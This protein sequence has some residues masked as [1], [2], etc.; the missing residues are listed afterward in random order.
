MKKTLF[1]IF[2]GLT[3]LMLFSGCANTYK[4]D[5]SFVKF[6]LQT[7]K[8][9]PKDCVVN[10]I[11]LPSNICS[12]TIPFERKK[13]ILA[14]SMIKDDSLKYILF[15]NKLVYYKNALTQKVQE[16]LFY[17]VKNYLAK[18]RIKVKSITIHHFVKVYANITINNSNGKVYAVGKISKRIIDKV[19]ENKNLVK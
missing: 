12:S 19:F 11:N 7:K 5:N 13:Y 17:E 9:N 10:D 18:K 2:T 14:S 15:Q 16:K 4:I 1:P 6:S 8:S 3:G